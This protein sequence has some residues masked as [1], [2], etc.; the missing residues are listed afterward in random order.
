M[1][2]RFLDTVFSGGVE[3]E[4]G[5]HDGFTVKVYHRGLIHE[6]FLAAD[7]LDWEPTAVMAPLSQVPR[8]LRNYTQPVRVTVSDTGLRVESLAGA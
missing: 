5:L 2:L 8:L 3:G 7:V 4:V 1:A 6:V